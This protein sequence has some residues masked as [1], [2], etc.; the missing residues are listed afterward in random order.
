MAT[1]ARPTYLPAE[2]VSL[3]QRAVTVLLS[4][5]LLAALLFVGF[6]LLYGA[7]LTA[8][9]TFDAVSY[10]NQIGRVYEATGDRH[11]LFHPH[12]LLFNITN[13]GIWR[14]AQA[15]GYVGGPLVVMERVNSVLGAS[16]IAL[17]YLT[18][19]RL[20]ARSRGL[21]ALT[22]IGLGVSFGYWVCATD[23]R[24][25]M[26]SLFLL[27]A[28]FF[29]LCRM[30]LGGSRRS[31]AGVGMLTGLALLYHESAGLFLPVGLAGIA[32]TAQHPAMRV[33]LLLVYAAAW[34]ATVCL[35]YFLVA[36]LA[37]HL[38]SWAAFH[39]WT[40]EYAELGWWWSFNVPHNLRLDLYA[41][42][43][44]AFA[45]PPGKQG[46]FSL[47]RHIP[48]NIRLLYFGALAG[49]LVSVYAF[50]AALP[51][52]WRSHHRPTLIACL[53]WIGC[54]ATFFTFWC[55]GYFVFW[56]PVLVPISLLLTLGL[57]HFRSGRS[58]LWVNWLVAFWIVLSAAVNWA[59]SIGPHLS[60]EANPFR[61]IAADVK[62]HTH[63]G[64]LVLLAGAGDQ[65]QDEVFLPYFADR[66][67]VSLHTLLTRAHNHSAAAYAAAQA[68]MQSAWA[69][70]HAVYGLDEL[71]HGLAAWN[72]LDRRHPGVG[73]SDLTGWA[74]RAPVPAWIDLHGRPVWRLLPP[75]TSTSKSEPTS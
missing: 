28:A 61:R 12:H 40:T 70:G 45:E 64:D 50:F 72:A 19:R 27:L 55:A 32:L 31:A 24:V 36:T 1:D 44:A 4:D 30:P 13:Y 33:R 7:T 25:N 52:L 66:D 11:W 43:H 3:R 16:G 9:N 20:M 23:G 51:L 56:V 59:D 69:S 39:T 41:L 49:W 38:H 2:A 63:P 71:W 54:Y 42:R 18:L 75:P 57:C 10:A 73:P 74:V 29:G 21:P 37:L 65:A 48:L 46:T 60:P 14:A 17:F 47:A 35:P 26:P 67:V 53:I 5:T 15:G 8:Y 68:Q 34:A 6:A 62:A 22:A 58:G